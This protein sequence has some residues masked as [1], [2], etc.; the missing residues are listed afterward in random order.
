[1]GALEDLR[2]EIEEAATEGDLPLADRVAR[3]ESIGA[4]LQAAIETVDQKIAEAEADPDSQRPADVEI[5]I[6]ALRSRAETAQEQMDSGTI[7]EADLTEAGIYTLA[8]LDTFAE[9]GLLET[10]AGELIEDGSINVET[11]EWAL[12]ETT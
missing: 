7:T 4:D 2:A 1:M 9:E 3:L 5:A 8:E 12:A 10:V 6:A 11:G